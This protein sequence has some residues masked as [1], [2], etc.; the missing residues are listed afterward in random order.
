MWAAASTYGES[1]AEYGWRADRIFA[2]LAHRGSCGDELQID[3]AGGV[4]QYVCAA[5]GCAS[6]R[7]A[8]RVLAL[9]VVVESW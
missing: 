5:D 9:A 8:A 2:G 1:P 6:V 7:V 4:V 3:M